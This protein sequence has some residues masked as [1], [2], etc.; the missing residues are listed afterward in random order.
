MATQKLEGDVSITLCK[1][2]F[3]NDKIVIDYNPEE[4]RVQKVTDDGK[5]L[6]LEYS[7]FI[8]V[9]DLCGNHIGGISRSRGRSLF[10]KL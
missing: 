10:A 3:V 7:K 4:C 9:I 6:Q 2:S 5:S 8:P 1:I